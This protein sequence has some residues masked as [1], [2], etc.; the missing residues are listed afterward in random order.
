MRLVFEVLRYVDTR[1]YY[2]GNFYT[3]LFNLKTRIQRACDILYCILESPI[4]GGMTEMG[5]RGNITQD[6]MGCLH[7]KWS[8]VIQNELHGV[9]Y[10]LYHCNIEG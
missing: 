6:V 9:A 7:S 5:A 1:V 4:K 10:L 2:A 8:D 3:N